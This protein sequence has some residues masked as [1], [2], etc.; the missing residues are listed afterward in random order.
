MKKYT[1]DEINAIVAKKFKENEMQFLF[2]FL[3]KQI[4]IENNL[5]IKNKLLLLKAECYQRIGELSSAQCVLNQVDSKYISM[6]ESINLEILKLKISFQ[7]GKWDNALVFSNSLIEQRV[8][9]ENILWRISMLYSVFNDENESARYSSQHK[10][11]IEKSG[12][13][14]ANN[15]VYTQMIPKLLKGNKNVSL[16]KAISPVEDAEHIYLNSNVNFDTNRR[17]GSRLKSFCQAILIEAFIKW[18]YANKYDAYVLAILTGLC[19]AYSNITLDAEGIGEIIRLFKQKF[20]ILILIVNLALKNSEEK[21]YIKTQKF[22]DFFLLKNAYIDAV[23]R[24]EDI[25]ISNMNFENESGI[26]CVDPNEQS[27]PY[28]KQDSPGEQIKKFL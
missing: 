11:L 4:N 15:I 27:I 16:L 20:Q 25:M 21:F 7:K 8:L 5:N 1:F 12:F 13:Q 26:G 9:K 22:A 19:M 6:E 18:G 14:E 23:Y 24:F 28:Q 17:V 2:S 3:A 10:E